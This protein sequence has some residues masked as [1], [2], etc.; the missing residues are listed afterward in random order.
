MQQI[1]KIMTWYTLYNIWNIVN[2]VCKVSVYSLNRPLFSIIVVVVCWRERRFMSV[3]GAA[4]CSICSSFLT[5]LTTRRYSRASVK[6]TQTLFIVCAL[7]RIQSLVESVQ[8][9]TFKKAQLHPIS[10]TECMRMANLQY[11]L[12]TCRQWVFVWLSMPIL[13]YWVYEHTY[14]KRWIRPCTSVN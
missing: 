10:H 7:G 4:F 1:I 2:S 9:F 3:T 8:N 11:T 12:A 5:S 6:M 13:K 14:V